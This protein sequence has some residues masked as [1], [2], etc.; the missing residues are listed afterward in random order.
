[1]DDKEVEKKG[2]FGMSASIDVYKMPR[3]EMWKPHGPFRCDIWLPG[4]D[5]HGIGEIPNQALTRALDHW[6]G[7]HSKEPKT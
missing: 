7:Y 2:G 1:M 3:K 4:E 5:H 6:R